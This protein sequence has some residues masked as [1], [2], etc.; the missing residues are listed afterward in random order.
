M[1]QAQQP[2]GWTRVM[3]WVARILAL[4]VIG[5]FVVFA[6]Q[7]GSKVLSALS[8]DDPQGLPLLLALLLA[9]AGV[10]I[11]WRW[12]LVGGIMA[13]VGAIAIVSLT[14]LGSGSD[15]LLCSLLFTGPLLLAGILYLGSCLRT[16]RGVQQA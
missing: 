15:M 3:R 5:L 2:N 14:C 8:F 9:L 4:V 6:V 1:T 11:A 7:S 13:I 10:L 16:V 12:E